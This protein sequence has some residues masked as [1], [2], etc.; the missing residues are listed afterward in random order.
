[1]TLAKPVPWQDLLSKQFRNV[2]DQYGPNSQMVASALM[3]LGDAPLLERVGEP[4][5]ESASLPLGQVTIVTSWEDALPIFTDFPRYNI[6]G[7]LQAACDPCDR[8]INGD[9]SREAWWQR[10]REDA[11]QYAS[12][13]GSIPNSLSQEHQDLMFEHL[14]EYVSMLLAEIIAAP[15]VECTYFR[16]QLSWFHAGHFPCGWDGDWPRGHMRVY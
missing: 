11:K 6:N 3:A 14:Y 7:V 1:M 15:S 5:L 9:P 4:W 10:A 12:L 8:I 16:E 13:M 2:S